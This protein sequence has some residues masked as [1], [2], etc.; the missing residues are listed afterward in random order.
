M[1]AET[2]TWVHLLLPLPPTWSSEVRPL[3]IQAGVSPN[4]PTFNG[5]EPLS[6]ETSIPTISRVGP[7]SAVQ[8]SSLEPRASEREVAQRRLVSELMNFRQIV[9]PRGDDLASWDIDAATEAAASLIN[10]LPAHVPLPRPMLLSEQ[11]ALYWD[12]GDTYAEIDF[13]GTNFLDGY[14]K[15]KGYPE[16]FL[17]RFQIASATGH[18]SFPSGIEGVISGNRETLAA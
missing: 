16:V 18:V 17:D 9:H 2:I 11:V 3:L 1:I 12:F 6:D 8:K 13:D 10:A 5:T 14:G 7:V 15:R 4:H